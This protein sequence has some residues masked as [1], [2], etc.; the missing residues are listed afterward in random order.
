MATIETRTTK[1]GTT[2]RVRFGR[3]TDRAGESF[4]SLAGAESF[5][6][7][8]E[9]AG[10]TWPPGWTPGV[11]YGDDERV[12]FDEAAQRWMAAREVTTSPQTARRYRSILEHE[13]L[14]LWRDWPVDAIGLEDVQ[15]WVGGRHRRGSSRAT[16]ENY[17]TVLYGVLERATVLGQRSAN[18]CRLVVLPA[19]AKRPEAHGYLTREQVWALIDAADRLEH[20]DAAAFIHAAAITGARW[21]ELAALVGAD[22]ERDDSGIW[23]RVS[24]AISIQPDAEGVVRGVVTTPKTEAGY[25]TIYVA[26]ADGAWLVEHAAAITRGPLFPAPRGG[27]WR[28][29]TF[30][31][32]RWQPI[33]AAAR[34][35]VEL[36]AEIRFHHLRHS[37]AWWAMSAGVELEFLRHQMGHTDINMTART[38]GGMTTAGRARAGR[39][40]DYGRGPVP[41]ITAVVVDEEAS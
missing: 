17:L 34:E 3:G 10:N 2:W 15:G 40:L 38:Y 27:V 33:V 18:P 41:E 37:Y 24:K 25:R 32:Y 8:V 26:P 28:Y 21:G 14:P 39:L 22:V 23:V 30:H 16:I 4:H 19:R 5:R 36:P 20:R 31:T 7:D 1:S 35:D 13:F 29:S 11:G 12:T 6:R 9:R